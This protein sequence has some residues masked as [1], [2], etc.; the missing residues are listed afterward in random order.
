MA[1]KIDLKKTYRQFYLPSAKEPLIVEIPSFNFLMIDG[2]DARPE[3]ESFQ[4]AIR[5]LFSV[6]Y[7]AKFLSKK[8]LGKDYVVM[9]LEGLW[10]ADEMDDFL[11][12]KKENWRWTLMIHQPDLITKE[13]INRSIEA[14]IKKDPLSSLEQL[15]LEKFAE[16]KS[17]QILHIGPYSEEHQNILKIHH[18]IHEHGGHF[19]WQDQKHHEIYLSDFRKVVPEKLK[20]VIRQAFNK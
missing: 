12:G 3:S 5:A 14:V 4:E 6:S 9:P 16:G 20:T 13:M 2:I 11:D 17:G 7:K 8:E 15:R 19:N 18:M 10:W 1:A